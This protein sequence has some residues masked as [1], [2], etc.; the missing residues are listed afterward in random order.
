MNRNILWSYD[1]NVNL[2]LLFLTVR[3][4]L[5]T[6][7]SRHNCLPAP[8]KELAAFRSFKRRPTQCT[9][10]AHFCRIT[11]CLK[12]CLAASWLYKS[13]ELTEI[14]IDI[15]L[16]EW[17][18]DPKIF[19]TY[20]SFINRLKLHNTLISPFKLSGDSFLPCNVHSAPYMIRGVYSRKIGLVMIWNTFSMY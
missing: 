15:M 8:G 5:Q 2:Q 10:Q 13:Y 14:A 12:G 6:V 7:M 17:E 16:Y 11:F 9:K 18:V 3:S 19:M 1:C 20:H 4:T